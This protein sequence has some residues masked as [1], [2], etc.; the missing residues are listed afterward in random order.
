MTKRSAP[1][2]SAP[3]V[4]QRVA[5]CKKFEI[6]LKSQADNNMIILHES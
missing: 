4:A 1:N 2:R 5:A 6:K 3:H